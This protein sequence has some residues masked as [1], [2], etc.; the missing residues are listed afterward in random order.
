MRLLTLVISLVASSALTAAAPL[1]ES[2]RE[3][4]C[5]WDY[6]GVSINHAYPV[7]LRLKALLTLLSVLQWRFLLD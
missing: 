5:Q 7:H 2:K 1:E 3:E 4:E 6:C